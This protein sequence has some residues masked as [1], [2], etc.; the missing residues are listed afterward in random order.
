MLLALDGIKLPPQWRKRL[1]QGMGRFC[2]LGGVH[3][4]QGR[5]DSGNRPWV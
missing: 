3:T 1:E 2:E 5:R 4:I